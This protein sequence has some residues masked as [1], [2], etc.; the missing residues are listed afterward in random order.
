[1]KIV[2]ALLA[3][4]FDE[5]MARLR[6]AEAFTGYVQIDI[7]DGAFVPTRSFSPERLNAVTTPLSFELHLMVRDPLPLIERISNPGLRKI[8]FHFESKARHADLI[9]T[10]HAGGLEAGLAIRPETA[11]ED[12]RAAA[13]RADTLLFLTVDPGHYGSPFRPEVLEKIAAARRMFPD[14]TISADGGVS[15]DNLKDFLNRRVDYV[16][17]G[18]RIFLKGNPGDNYRAFVQRLQDLEAVRA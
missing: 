12:F 8:L 10:I 13:E 11:P 9:D 17:I 1:M 14:K 7:M 16:C 18:S 2:P 3:E 5:F 4:D 6:Q 15:L